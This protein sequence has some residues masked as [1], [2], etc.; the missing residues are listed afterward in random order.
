MT[1]AGQAL[2]KTV[3]ARSGTKWTGHQST[4]IPKR[5]LADGIRR[6]VVSNTHPTG[7]GW[8]P[9]RG[10]CGAGRTQRG[11]CGCYGGLG[12]KYLPKMATAAANVLLGKQWLK[13]GIEVAQND[14]KANAHHLQQGLCH[15]E[16][17]TPLLHLYSTVPH[18]GGEGHTAGSSRY[19]RFEEKSGVRKWGP[20]VIRQGI[21]L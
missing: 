7:Q 11:C 18:M 20:F 15:F 13:T 19:S 12:P 10:C 6:N 4:A 16:L 1:F 14:R 3:E 21:I 9:K 5:C 2:I 17:S 8:D